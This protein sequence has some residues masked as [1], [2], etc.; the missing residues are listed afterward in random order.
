MAAFHSLLN[1]K[2]L[3][4]TPT[5]RRL[6]LSNLFKNTSSSSSKNNNMRMIFSLSFATTALYISMDDTG[7][8]I[9]SSLPSYPR[10]YKYNKKISSMLPMTASSFLMFP[11]IMQMNRNARKPKKA[12]GGNRP[13]SSVNRRKRRGRVKVKNGKLQR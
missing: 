9:S 11:P 2:T 1:T 7:K 8:N 3:L 5:S 12:N 4:F 10:D 13:C 6:L